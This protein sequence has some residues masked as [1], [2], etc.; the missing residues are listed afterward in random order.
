MGGYPPL[1]YDPKDRTL[2]VNEA[3]ADVVRSIFRRYLELGSVHALRDELEQNGILT[4]VVTSKAGTVRGGVPFGRGS[5]FHLLKNRVYLGEI[6]HK[7]TSYP[8]LHTAI[9]EPE[10]FDAVQ[11]K[12]QG[13]RVKR[14]ERVPA[15]S[16][17]RH[18]PRCTRQQD[19]GDP[20]KG[21]G[22]QA[23]CLLRFPRCYLPS[24]RSARPA[25]LDA[26]AGSGLV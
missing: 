24:R 12:L 6:V 23:V 13:R 14:R 15:R 25:P 3:E 11:A 10:L 7:G 4:K 17:G 26:A 20:C 2:V 16:A 21:K 5:L 8:G 19:V 18:P 22:R 9:I 1:G